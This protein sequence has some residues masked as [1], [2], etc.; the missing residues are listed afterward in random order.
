MS[1][2]RILSLRPNLKGTFRFLFHLGIDKVKVNA[3]NYLTM[4]TSHYGCSQNLGELSIK[5][6]KIAKALKAEFRKKSYKGFIPLLAYSGMSGITFAT[7]LSFYL[8]KKKALHGM[9]YV[10]KKNEQSHG[11]MIELA[12]HSSQNYQIVFVD[13]FVSSGASCEYV[14]KQC[15]D[16]DTSMFPRSTLFCIADA[17]KNKV[18]CALHDQIKP[19]IVSNESLAKKIAKNDKSVNLDNSINL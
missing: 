19:Y 17:K 10:R 12:T 2:V 6:E 11:G 7:M 16:T 13:D 15:I 5:A 18:L 9:A 3:Y 1:R 4:Y 8:T 14:L